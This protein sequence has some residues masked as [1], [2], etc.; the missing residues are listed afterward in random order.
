MPSTSSCCCRREGECD[1]GDF[2][3][4]TICPQWM[5]N[6]QSNR[7]V[8]HGHWTFQINIRL[9][10][11]TESQTHQN[12]RLGHLPCHISQLAIGDNVI[13]SS[14]L[15]ASHDFLPEHCTWTLGVSECS[16]SEK[17]T[18]DFLIN[19]SKTLHSHTW[20]YFWNVEQFW[21]RRTFDVCIIVK[22]MVKKWHP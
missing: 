3:L 12:E 11:N 22:H 10:W 7:G 13:G 18:T 1:G 5:F 8:L 2:K 21:K 14:S 19:N 9:L 6:V 20:G 17:K 15:C 16:T 4:H